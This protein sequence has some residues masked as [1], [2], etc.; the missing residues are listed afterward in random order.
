MLHLQLY[1]KEKGGG[2]HIE[3]YCIKSNIYAI[4]KGLDFL[5]HMLEIVLPVR[6]LWGF[7]RNRTW[8]GHIIIRSMP[9][10]ISFI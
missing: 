9:V 2:G 6:Y 4:G 5:P 1:E 10:I 3:P 8:I 7:S